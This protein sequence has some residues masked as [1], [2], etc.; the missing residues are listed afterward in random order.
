MVVYS[1]YSP[2]KGSGFRMRR[3]SWSFAIDVTEA[4]GDADQSSPVAPIETNDVYALHRDH[5]VASWP[6]RDLRYFLSR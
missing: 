4:P 3:W 2:F 6:V 5:V 1:G